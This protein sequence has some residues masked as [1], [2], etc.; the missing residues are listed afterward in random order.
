MQ[1]ENVLKILVICTGNSARSQ[2]AEGFFKTYKKEWQIYSA[3]TE[4]KGLNPLAVEA[5]SKSG[6]DI[7]GYKSKNIDIFANEIFDYV[8]TV[9]DKARE[10]CP[11]FPGEAKYV[12]WSF[13]DPAAAVGT[14]EEK[15]EVFM[16][17]RD[18]IMDK[19]LEFIK[20]KS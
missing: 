8:V 10:S 2:M 6:I 19:I 14:K 5:M 4:P 11:L 15:L 16:K 13:Y 1:K 17:I 7:S 9:C 12:H 20:L 3:G 18:E